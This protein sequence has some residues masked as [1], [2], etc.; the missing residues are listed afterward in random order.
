MKLGLKVTIKSR[1][2]YSL[3]PDVEMTRGAVHGCG[4]CLY[5][6]HN[7]L[8]PFRPLQSWLK[9]QP[10]FVVNKRHKNI[11]SLRDELCSERIRNV[12]YLLSYSKETTDYGAC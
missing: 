2:K 6:H 7:S 12:F 8:S 5:F 1:R 3:K 4:F 11:Y 9:F 10:N